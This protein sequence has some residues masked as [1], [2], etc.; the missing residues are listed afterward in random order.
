M[1][2]KLLGQ[3]VYFINLPKIFRNKKSINFLKL[4]GLNWLNFQEYRIQEAASIG[5]DAMLLQK[6]LSSY[7]DKINIANYFTEILLKKGCHKNDLKSFALSKTGIF[8]RDFCTL[9]S[10][11]DYLK[12]DEKNKFIIIGQFPHILKKVFNNK[13]KG[14]AK[15]FNI[16]SFGYILIVFRDMF[17]KILLSISKKFNK[18]VIFTENKSID[19]KKF[20]TIFFPHQGIYY[21]SMYKKDH[22]YSKE[23][24]SNFYHSNILHISSGNIINNSLTKEFYKK[25][26]ITEIDFNSLGKIS[27]KEVILESLKIIPRFYFF[28]KD[29]FQT[30]IFFMGLWFSIKQSLLR[31]DSLPNAQSAIFGYDL[32]SPRDIA[33]ACEIKKI[34]TVSTQERYLSVWESDSFFILDHYLTINKKAEEQISTEHLGSIKKMK[35]IGP[36]RSDL[37]INDTDKKKN[38]SNSVVLVLDSHSHINYYQNGLR[39]FANWYDNYLFYQ[40]ILELSKKNKNVNFIIKG[41]NYNFMDISYFSNIKKLINESSNIEVFKSSNQNNSAYSLIEKSVLTISRHTSIVDEILFKKLPL[42]I[43]DSAGYPSTFFNYG[44]SLVVKNYNQLEEKFNLWKKDPFTFQK[45]ILNET[46]Q[47]LHTHKPDDKVY[48]FLHDYLKKE[49]KY[50]S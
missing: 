48:D 9:I 19:L 40:D 24:N 41:K 13:I 36:I 29:N 10:F 17:I 26:N 8:C 35:S 30:I 21:G 20:K 47:Y 50:Y 28:S 3:K 23:I 14:K 43:Y 38:I 2:F 1:F 25:N 16:I 44:K 34:K 39:K 22:F 31:L 4:I 46:N 42:I 18:K 32:L 7:I 45:N 33:I 6:D 11:I 15:L 27:L 12:K 49:F 5:K 37:I